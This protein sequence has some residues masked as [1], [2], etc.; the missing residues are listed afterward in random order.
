L[1]FPHNFEINLNSKVKT[2][3]MEIIRDIAEELKNAYLDYAMSVI[4]G[5]ALPDV[6][7]GLKPVQRRILYAMYEMGLTHNKPHVKCARVVGY[8]LG[9]YH[10]H[11]DAPVYDAL[12]RMAQEFV[13]RYPLIDG[14]GNFGSVDGDEPAA[15]RYTECRL[16]EISEFMLEDVE[17]TVDF[18]PNFDSSKVEPTVLPAKVPNL[19][20]NGCV[21]IAVGMAT[22]IPPHN[23]REV[24]DGIVAYI[25]NPEIDVDGL[26]RYI[27]GPDF[28]TGGVIVGRDGIFEAYRTGKGKIVLRGKFEVEGNKIIIREIPY[29][30][31]KSKLI[32]KIADLIKSGK[33]HARTVVDESDREGIRI[34]VDIRE[35]PNSALKK[36]LDHTPLKV[37]FNMINLALVNNEPKLLNLKEMIEQFV[38]HRRDVLRRKMEFELKRALERIHVIEG[39]MRA[40]ERIDEVVDI[41]RRSKSVEDARNSLKDVL[42]I[43]DRQAESILRLRLQ[44]ITKLE[45]EKLT[46]EHK[47]LRRRID[48]LRDTLSDPSKIDGLIVEEL[49][50]LKERFGDERRTEIVDEEKFEE[51]VEEF[52]VLIVDGFVRRFEIGRSLRVKSG[53]LIRARSDSR[54]L[55][56]SNNRVFS[57]RA[58]DVPIEQTPISRFVSTNKIETCVVADGDVVLLSRDGYLRRVKLEEFDS[59]KRSGI[60]VGNVS[61]ARL[62]SKGYVLI[63][64]KNGYVVRFKSSDVPVYGR[65]AKGVRG[66]SLREGDEIAWISIGDGREILILT[67]DGYAKRLPMDEVR[68]TSRGAMGVLGVRGEIAVAEIISSEQ[69]YAYTSEGNPV[70]INV[71]RIPVCNR[72][73]K[74]K[75]VAKDF[76]C[77]VI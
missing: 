72:Y 25:R 4:V 41:L 19:L 39:L 30:V 5:R 61:F 58:K 69:Y 64:T 45:Y 36:L 37:S 68:L 46:R 3:F 63:A 73:R 1:N 32:E 60:Q 6:R 71:K 54:I 48:I 17:N 38:S 23:L 65:T 62:Y 51:R 33:L 56:F 14:Q 9:N 21:G 8:V 2:E 70:R 7:D 44:T 35:D 31:N 10:P 13:M 53:I 18:Q 55:L 57:I 16:T 28:P 67:R 76:S 11:G 47:T 59:A 27:K 12:V 40:L 74:G 20:I 43:T 26:M 24:C 49:I 77:I 42:K 50:H 52:G 15:M 22:N 34:V 66:I 75:K 29:M